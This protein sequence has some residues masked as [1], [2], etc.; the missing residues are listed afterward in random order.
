MLHWCNGSISAFQAFGVGSNPI[1]NSKKLIKNMNRTKQYNRY[2]SKIK[3]LR[4][5]KISDNYYCCISDNYN[6]H[7]YSSLH[8]YSKGKIHCSCPM[9]TFK[10][11]N[12]HKSINGTNFGKYNYKISELKKV[13]AM[14]DDL[15]EYILGGE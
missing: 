13:Q 10:T 15:N 4:K 8:M 2:K 9:C 5:K 11:K 6:H 7:Y 12:T 3:A 1:C 14:L